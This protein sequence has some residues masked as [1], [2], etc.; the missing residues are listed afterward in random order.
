M[1][2]GLLALVGLI[3]FLGQLVNGLKA[4]EVFQ[5]YHTNAV[6]YHGYLYPVIPGTEE[7]IALGSYE[8]RLASVQ[9]PIDTLKDI[10]TARLLETCLYNPFMIDVWALDDHFY[11][12]E[13]LRGQLNCLEEFYNRE[14]ALAELISLYSSR[15]VE[16]VFEIQDPYDRG[17][18]HADYAYM[19]LMMAYM[20]TIMD[21]SSKDIKDVVTALLDKTS[22]WELY[23]DEY[24]AAYR[25][26]VLLLMGRLLND[27]GAF[28]DYQG[29][30]LYYFLENGCCMDVNSCESDMDYIMEVARRFT[31]IEENVSS[32]SMMVF[33]NPTEGFVKFVGN[34]V[35]RIE[36]YNVAGQ[37]VKETNNNV[38]DLS[39]Q[40]AGTYIIK[41]I[42]PSGTITKQIIKK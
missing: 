16:F 36:V 21:F 6:P 42:T 2:K 12:M 23:Y 32:Q 41:V 24:G 33:P 4:Q 1:K 17:R 39:D 26:D 28:Y 9:L 19:E 7:W 10:S 27:E 11:C 25:G 38:L 35:D 34:E 22:R 13:L 29:T 5:P 15:Q 31:D 37:L 30:T 18:Y 3:L 8:A 40:E 20:N 14:D